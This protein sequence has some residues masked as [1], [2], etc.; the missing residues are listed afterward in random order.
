MANK[1]QEPVYDPLLN[2]LATQ[3]AFEKRYPQLS[4]RFG[5]NLPSLDWEQTL[6]SIH[7][8]VPG[9]VFD[10][11]TA[12]IDDLQGLEA[13]DKYQDLSPASIAKKIIEENKLPVDIV[14]HP[15]SRDSLG[16]VPI[17]SNSPRYKIGR[18]PEAIP[19]EGE[20]D[21]YNK[22]VS[23]GTKGLMGDEPSNE[24]I[25][26]INH[27][28]HHVKDYVEHPEYNAPN[29]P[30]KG[31]LLARD[32][33]I[34]HGVPYSKNFIPQEED[35]EAVREAAMP[36]AEKNKDLGKIRKMLESGHMKNYW[37]FDSQFP[38]ESMYHELEKEGVYVPGMANLTKDDPNFIHSKLSDQMLEQEK[39][40]TTPGLL[41]GFDVNSPDT[42]AKM[43][44]LRR[45]LGK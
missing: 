7:K 9:T 36:I 22:T 31:S 4:S 25:A 14:K 34:E 27:E 11:S 19:G 38:R 30:T 26:T 17:K 18:N 15:Y 37:D 33:A 2:Q 42:I 23:V 28:L 12:A 8:T 39:E 5:K 35:F 43:E 45:L 10:W 41:S 24:L 6:Q 21:P 32:Y 29:H 44:H 40:R 3:E 16:N 1:T 20:T 13:K